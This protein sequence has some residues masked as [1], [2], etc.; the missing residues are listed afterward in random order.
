M[1]PNRLTLTFLPLTKSHLLP[2]SINSQFF[3][4]SFLTWISNCIHNKSSGATIKEIKC[5][6]RI[7]LLLL[8]LFAVCKIGDGHL[9]ARSH[10]YLK[11]LESWHNWNSFCFLAIW[12]NDFPHG[13]SNTIDGLSN[14]LLSDGS[15]GLEG[16]GEI[17]ASAWSDITDNGGFIFQ[18]RFEFF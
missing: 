16:S 18:A 6:L 8:V 4:S 14:R 13:G 12:D 5:P 9:K 1:Q 2:L 17:M 7:N 3:F 10:L 11:Y 15:A